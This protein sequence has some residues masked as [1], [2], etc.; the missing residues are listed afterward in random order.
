[1]PVAHRVCAVIAYCLWGRTQPAASLAPKNC[2]QSKRPL[3][4]AK[5]NGAF[6]A[7]DGAGNAG[8]GGGDSSGGSGGSGGAGG[9]ESAEPAAGASEA[10]V[11]PGP[12][13]G[14]S[15]ASTSGEARGGSNA[16]ESLAA[17]AFDPP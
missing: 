15:R 8:S 11:S 5:R 16:G 3:I 14:C 7:A 2:P 4:W 6:E 10:L 12:V 1:M 13:G 17:A 9:G